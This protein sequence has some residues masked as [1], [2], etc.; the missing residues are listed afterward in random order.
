MNKPPTTA[1]LEPQSSVKT[2]LNQAGQTQKG[3]VN[4]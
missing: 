2:Q 4:K 1:I 3:Q